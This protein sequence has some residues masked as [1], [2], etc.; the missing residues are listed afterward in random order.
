VLAC[1]KFLKR[2]FFSEARGPADRNETLGCR[3]RD[4][5]WERNEG[6]N[7]DQK[8]SV[9][10]YVVYR[11]SWTGSSVVTKSLVGLTGDESQLFTEGCAGALF[12]CEIEERRADG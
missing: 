11:C 3:R 12:R 5:I 2:P 4:E 10:E 8:R 7:N 6:V 1:C 9:V